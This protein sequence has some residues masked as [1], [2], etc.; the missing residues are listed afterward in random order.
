MS[1]NAKARRARGRQEA[2]RQELQRQLEIERTS[3]TR[4]RAKVESM[5]SVVALVADLLWT[6]LEDRVVELVRDEV[7]QQLDDL[8]VSR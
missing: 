2:Q 5:S 1:Q 3:H 6:R 4:T 7:E 8:K